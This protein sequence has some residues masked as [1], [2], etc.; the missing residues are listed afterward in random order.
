MIIG[1]GIAA[2]SAAIYSSRAN[3]KVLVLSASIPLDQL[4]MTS[5]V[6]NYAGFPE[7]VMGPK[8]IKD[9]KLQAE[10]FGAEYKSGFVESIK[11]IKNGFKISTSDKE[12]KSKTVIIATG[13]SPKKL[14]IPGEENYFGK[15]VS[16]CATCDAALFKNKQVVIVGGGDTSMEYALI[17]TKFTDNVTIIH[18][19]DKFRASEIMQERVFK[20]KDKINIIWDSEIKEIRGDGNFVSEI[21]IK[22]NK[23]KKDSI[24]KCEGIFLG[25]GH[26]PNT[27]PFKKILKL[28]EKGYIK[29]KDSMSTD[30]D[31]IFAAGDCQD[32][33]YWQAIVAA[34]SGC[35]SALEA[36]KYISN[37]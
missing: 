25:I 3:L 37:L 36:E 17:L 5:L 18:R 24:L 23:N 15:G 14:K 16:T 12:Y 13:A 20:L 2:H 33:K 8:L 6:E 32:K 10:K 7:G 28:D 1:G 19:K 26:T 27:G 22:N 11:K 35:I 4:S 29:T 31:G 30:I 34:G 9:C 21:K